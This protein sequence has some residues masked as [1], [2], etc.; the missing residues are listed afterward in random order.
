VADDDVVL[1]EDSGEVVWLTL[2]RADKK[3]AVSRAMGNRLAQ[4]V[5]ELQGRSD[6][7]A[8]VLAAEGD[9]FCAGADLKERK[10]MSMQEVESFARSMNQLFVDIYELPMPT[11]SLLQ[12]P[13]YG[14]GCELSLCTDFRVVSPNT[15]FV[16]PETSLGIIPGWGGTQRLPAL[17]GLA[18]AK[19]M[20]LLCERIDAQTALSWG[21]A[22]KVAAAEALRQ[23]AKNMVETIKALGP[24]GVRQAK[25]AIHH[26]RWSRDQYEGV[27]FET[28]CYQVV[29]HSE[30]RVEAL[31]AFAEK[32]KPVFKGR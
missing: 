11:I 13:A 31:N 9:V 32:R 5:R 2:N 1:V 18:R 27:K 29:L 8:V 26:S 14:G 16:L 3:N 30:D 23:E 17:I 28:D 19:Q 24:L 7:R 22:N 4:I 20:I 25:Q 6:V 12:G 15:F 21:L 10:D